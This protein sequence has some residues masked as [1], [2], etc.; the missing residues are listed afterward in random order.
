MAMFGLQFSYARITLSTRAALLQGMSPS[1]FVVYRQAI[2]TLVIA[3]LAYFTRKKSGGSSMG[4]RNFSLIFL[5]SLIGVAINE[6]IY[7]QGLLFVGNYFTRIL[8]LLTSMLINTL[9]MNF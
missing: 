8:D 5:V 3:P 7:F 9:N 4:L 6:N 2:A 1:V